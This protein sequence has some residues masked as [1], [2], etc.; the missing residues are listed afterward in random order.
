MW[1]WL[2]ATGQCSCKTEWFL[3]S[4]RVYYVRGV[5]AKSSELA[6]SYLGTTQRSWRQGLGDPLVPHRIMSLRVTIQTALPHLPYAVSSWKLP[7]YLEMFSIYLENKVLE[8]TRHPMLPQ[9]IILPR[10]AC[11]ST[12]TCRSVYPPHQQLAL[13][14]SAQ[15]EILQENPRSQ[16]NSNPR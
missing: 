6:F 16:I 1:P 7:I 2:C 5:N 13:C 12:Y 8:Q 4:R 10:L 14:R 15:S 3:L 11:I 9:W